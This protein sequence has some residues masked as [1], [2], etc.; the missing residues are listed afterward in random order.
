MPTT[1]EQIRQFAISGFVKRA[2]AAN[3]KMKISRVW[4]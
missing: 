1:K 4:V 3:L 2:K